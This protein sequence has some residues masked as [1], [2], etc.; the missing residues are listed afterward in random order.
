MKG[1]EP[2]SVPESAPPPASSPSLSLTSLG[3]PSLAP[4]GAPTPPAPPAADPTVPNARVMGNNFEIGGEA[5]DSGNNLDEEI[6]K[7]LSTEAVMEDRDVGKEDQILSKTG[8]DILSESV[9]KD[10]PTLGLGDEKSLAENIDTLESAKV[11]EAALDDKL[12][13]EL[14]SIVQQIQVLLF[15]CSKNLSK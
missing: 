5:A 9:V 4:P 2:A 12:S 1:Q 14:R 15:S 11:K 6:S 7:L 8:S 13:I 10:E 3:P